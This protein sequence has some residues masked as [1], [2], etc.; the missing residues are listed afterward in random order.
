LKEESMPKISRSGGATHAAAVPPLATGGTVQDP[1]VV[2]E[3]SPAP[4]VLPER[5]HPG[6]GVP[7]EGVEWP[8]DGSWS[9]EL[10]GDG[11]GE[12]LPPIEVSADGTL[13]P[14]VV[15]EDGEGEQPS[16]GSS[17]ETSPPKP[18]TSPGT[19]E[20]VLPKRARTTGSRSGKGRAGSSTARSTDTSTEADA[21]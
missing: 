13:S 12:A 1:P 5:E 14:E 15:V 19:S 9:P 4:S 2:G 17:S 16:A 7:T 11:S 3:D 8:A 20:A 18:P 21:S 10:E 6:T